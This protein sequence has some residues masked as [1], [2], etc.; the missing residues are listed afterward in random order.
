MTTTCDSVD[1][2]G[3]DVNVIVVVVVNVIVVLV[4]DKIIMIR[5]HI[6]SLLIQHNAIQHMN[7]FVVTT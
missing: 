6:N 2:D 1:N 3:V 5:P 7:E 4:A